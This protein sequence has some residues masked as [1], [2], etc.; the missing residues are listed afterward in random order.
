M[1]RSARRARVSQDVLADDPFAEL[2][3]ERASEPY[4]GLRPFKKGEWSIFFGRERMTADVVEQLLTRKIVLVHGASGCGKSS[5]VLAGVQAQLETQHARSGMSWRCSTMRPGSRPL[6]NLAAAITEAAP[7]QD[8]SLERELHRALNTTSGAAARVVELLDLSPEQRVCVV[9]DQFEELFRFAKEVSADQAILFARFLDSFSPPTKAPPGIHLLVTM[10]S[11]FLGECARLEGLATIVNSAQ[12]LLPRMTV[13]DLLR[14]IRDPAPLYGGHVEP[15]LAER[16]VADARSTQA[17]LPLMQHGMMRLWRLATSQT[18]GN[19]GV[20]VLRLSAYQKHGPLSRLLDAHADSVMANLAAG[21]TA[22][23]IVQKL[24][25]ALTDV[26]AEGAAIRRP[27]PLAAL[28]TVIGVPTD[29]LRCV[30]DGFR[31][32]GVSFLTPYA[33]LPLRDDSVID[34]SHEALIRCWQ[35]IGAKPDG[36]LLREFRDGQV[37]RSLRSQADAFRMDPRAVLSEAAAESRSAWIK[38]RNR[39]WADRYGGDWDAVVDLLNASSAAAERERHAREQALRD[40]ERAR[41]AEERAEQAER[42]GEAE[43][44]RTVAEAERAQK[45]REAAAAAQKLLAAE[46]NASRRR[47]LALRI[48]GVLLAVVALLA[49]VAVRQWQAAEYARAVAEQQEELAIA[50]KRYADQERERAIAAQRAAV[51]AQY[52]AEAALAAGAIAEFG[53]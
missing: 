4:P 27:Q 39:A 45:E 34:I 16:I 26:N 47:R 33:P 28:A 3:A 10:R 15:D 41:T 29:D 32:D 11:E 37:W 46:R 21:P 25:R 23:P 38:D 50:A 24:F 2:L 31:A 7:Q 17:E 5:L 9:I 42:L 20:V 36:W 22:S 35:R 49:A 40:Q 51:K 18:R 12:Y 43:R 48:G 6:Q 19:A 8:D 53:G 30:V 52:D 1:G 14:A 13:D 44:L